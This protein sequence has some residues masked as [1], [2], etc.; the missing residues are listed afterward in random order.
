MRLS[1]R[2]LL[3]A[4]VYADTRPPDRLWSCCEGLLIPSTGDDIFD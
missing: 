1:H 4:G 3:A 2:D